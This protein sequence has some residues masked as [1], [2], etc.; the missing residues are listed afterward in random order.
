MRN[1]TGVMSTAWNLGVNCSVASLPKIW[2]RRLLTEVKAIAVEKRQNARVATH[3][4]RE[5]IC[6]CV[7]GGREVPDVQ[8]AA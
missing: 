1:C 6:T 5:V 7:Y 4:K 8:G 2:L 3:R